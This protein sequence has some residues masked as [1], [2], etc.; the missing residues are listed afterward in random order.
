MRVFSLGSWYF[1]VKGHGLKLGICLLSRVAAVGAFYIISS[2]LF[3]LRLQRVTFQQVA[4]V[5]QRA[6]PT[7][8][9]PSM[10]IKAIL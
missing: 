4:L 9:I 2:G 3:E 6:W 1:F 7:T 5:G 10:L 8:Y